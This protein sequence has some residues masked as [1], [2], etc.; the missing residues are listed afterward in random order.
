MKPDV[1]EIVERCHAGAIC[2]SPA[3]DYL[4][5]SFVVSRHPG[6]VFFC[7]GHAH[8]GHLDSLLACPAQRH[9]RPRQ[10]IGR[11]PYGVKDSVLK[12]Q[13]KQRQPARGGRDYG[14]SH[15]RRLPGCRRG[16]GA[17]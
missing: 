14:T 6:E 11:I 2:K 5:E 7:E 16:S 9:F 13:Q 4:P 3:L 17:R 8:M 10:D 15:H 1:P 12:V